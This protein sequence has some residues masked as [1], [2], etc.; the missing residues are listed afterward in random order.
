MLASVSREAEEP[1]HAARSA[2]ALK[3]YIGYDGR[4]RDAY[5]V[6]VKSLLK[7]TSIP[8]CVTS[9]TAS[10]LTDSGLLS[11]Q[12]DRRG[13][14]MWDLVSNAPCSTEFSNSRFLTP[15][16]AQE[17]WALF[18]DCDVVFLEDIA[19]LMKLADPEYAVMV[20]KHQMGN[21]CGLKMDSQPQ[22]AYPKKNWSSVCLF[23]CDHPANRRLTIADVNTRPG[24][25]LHAFYWLNESEIGSLPPEWNWLVGVQDMPSHPKIAHYTLGVPSMVHS[26][27]KELW[28]A[29]R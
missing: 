17:G 12:I 13:P 14:V 11:R 22:V 29:E 10:R 9:L 1:G 24:R 18:T 19:E 20:V 27:H 5:A 26:E 4:E 15:M 3:V 28:E 23:N 2:Q 7:R 25:D 21:V 6:A 8:V 16:L